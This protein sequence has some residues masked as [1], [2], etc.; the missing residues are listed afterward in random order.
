MQRPK[1]A[2]PRRGVRIA[3]SQRW[4]ARWAAML[5]RAFASADYD[6]SHDPPNY[7]SGLAYYQQLVENTE[8]LQYPPVAIKQKLERLC[9][10]EPQIVLKVAR[11]AVT[12]VVENYRNTKASG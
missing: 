9:P 11:L 2:R 5:S 4:S 12:A 8:L 3:S 7:S 10:D 6:K 1:P